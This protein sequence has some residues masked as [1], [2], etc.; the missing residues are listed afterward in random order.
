[1]D[2]KLKV[3]GFDCHKIKNGWILDF[4]YKQDGVNKPE[5]EHDYQTDEIYCED[6]AKVLKKMEKIVEDNTE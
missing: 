1:M 5:V 2:K 6:F 3:V 4:Q